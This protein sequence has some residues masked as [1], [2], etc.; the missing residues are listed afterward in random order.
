M[1][2]S[3][4]E[5][6]LTTPPEPTWFYSR[7]RWNVHYSSACC[8][9]REILTALN[10]HKCLIN[11]H[12]KNKRLAFGFLKKLKHAMH[13]ELNNKLQ[14]HNKN[15]M[16]GNQQSKSDVVDSIN[17]INTTYDMLNGV[18]LPQAVNQDREARRLAA[19]LANGRNM[20]QTAKLCRIIDNE[21]EITWLQQSKIDYEKFKGLESIIWAV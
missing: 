21:K 3:D 20:D 14:V 10:L 8:I 5:E 4:E 6:E 19:L 9:D 17:H 18:I 7:Y 15:I 13:M 1:E 2:E 11:Q 16:N 12:R